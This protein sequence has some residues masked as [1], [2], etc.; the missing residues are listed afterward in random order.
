M[1]G[2]WAAMPAL[3]EQFVPWQEHSILLH[4]CHTFATE[5]KAEARRFKEMSAFDGCEAQLHFSI[6]WKKHYFKLICHL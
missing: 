5:W 4:L 3:L 2:M 1:L 6:F